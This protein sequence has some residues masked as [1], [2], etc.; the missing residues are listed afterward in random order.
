[1]LLMVSG[2]PIFSTAAEN[3][4]THVAIVVPSSGP[5]ANCSVAVKYMYRGSPFSKE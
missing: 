5:G 4:A 3:V 1:M 2:A